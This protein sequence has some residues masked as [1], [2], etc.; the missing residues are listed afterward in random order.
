MTKKYGHPVTEATAD[1]HLHS[2]TAARP[3]YWP[4]NQAPAKPKKG[5]G[6][7]KSTIALV[8]AAARILEEIQPAS[9]R[10][11]C[12]RLFVAGNIRS[13]S[14]NNT[15][16]VSRALVAAREQGLIPW[17][18]IVD[19]TRDA[20]RIRTWDNPDQIINAA[21]RTYRRDYWNDQPEWIEVWSEKGTI[22]GT[23]AP[24]LD[25]YGVTFRVMH[26]YTSATA[27]NNI[28]QETVAS[29]K[30]LTVL[31]LGDWDPSG[32]HMSEIDLPERLKRYGGKATIKRLALDLG[33]VGVNSPLP[34]FDAEDKV[35]DPRHQW[36]VKS[37]GRRCWELDALPPP[38][39]RARVKAAIN[40]LIDQPSWNRA[41]EVETAERESMLSFMDSWNQSKSRQAAKYSGGSK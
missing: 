20:E 27:I 1:Q 7:S 12:Y 33:D 21:V 34:S 15:N 6:K 3:L 16:A 22:R 23:L 18:W 25:E 35:N 10:A 17:E 32:L 29:P 14:K 38:E 30:K 41:I 31:Y 26:G 11:V 19:E 24:V 4:L 28:A 8:D 37:F 40:G 5:R 39:L 2:N 13:M 9:I 36:F